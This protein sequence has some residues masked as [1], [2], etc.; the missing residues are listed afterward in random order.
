VSVDLLSARPDVVYLRRR[1]K[2][3]E[4]PPVVRVATNFLDLSG[5][6]DSRRLSAVIP[7]KPRA[8]GTVVLTRA[9]PVVRLN[10]R[11]SAIGSLSVAGSA[12]FAWETRTRQNG[13]T[14]PGAA[15]PGMPVHANR[16][17]VE[18]IGA[19]AVVG[20]RHYAKLR[21]LIFGADTGKIT[22]TL[23][24]G[25]TITADTRDGVDVVHLSVVGLALEVRVETLGDGESI[26]STFSI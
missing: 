20:L 17:L 5:P 16:P 10:A 13:V 23:F 19:D 9:A 25:S 2:I 26:A 1:L 7:E 22:L 14:R 3:G 12:T 4:Q 15:A 8:A 11:Q 18:Y 21:R 24:D 6:E